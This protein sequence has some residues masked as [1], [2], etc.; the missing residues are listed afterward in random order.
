MKRY[1]AL[2]CV[3][4]ILL[5]CACNKEEPPSK[6]EETLQST[7][8][9]TT[10]AVTTAPQIQNP[11]NRMEKMTQ[12]DD[13][14]SVTKQAFS[15]NISGAVAYKI[16][17][18][19]EHGQLSADVVLPEDYVK[20]YNRYPVLIYFSDVKTYVDTLA[21][22]YAK[23]DIIVIHPYAR[24][25]DESEGMRDFGGAKDLADAQKLLE[26]FDAASFV[27]N[28]EVFVAGSAEGSVLALRLLAED[29]EKR[30]SGCAVVDVI[31]DIAEYSALRGEA[32]EK[33]SA[34]LIGKTYEEA[35]EEYELR[36]AI[37]FTEK[38]DRPILLLH[39]TQ[40]PFMFIE[41]TDAFYER[42]SVSN[43]DVTYHKIND[44]KSDFHGEAKDMLVAWINDK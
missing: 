6:T 37:N 33:I 3:A 12:L 23:N 34:A 11:I 39:F 17:Y 20:E 25:Y 24:G 42:L 15:T 4:L 14:I 5:L 28:S 22:D 31:T 38:L 30:I 41:M 7:K 16:I 21:A 43:D 26:I 8:N 29:E 44:L 1:I 40:S 32:I 35:P 10:A 13:V 9:T 36:S 27:E 2:I 19:S 18:G